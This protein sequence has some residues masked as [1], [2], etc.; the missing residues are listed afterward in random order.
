[1]ISFFRMI[2]FAAQHFFRNF[3]LSVVSII[4]LLLA[5]ISVN[6]FFGFNYVADR[7]I[8]TVQ[9]KIDLSLY[10]YQGIE[11]SEIAHVQ[12]YLNALS[13]VK[14]TEL[15]SA[16]QVLANFQ[17]KHKDNPDMMRSLTEVGGNPFGAMLILKVN[18][19]EDYNSVIASL[20]SDVFNKLI[21][22]RSYENHETAIRQLESFSRNV[23]IGL[24]AFTLL[25][26]FISMLIVYNT[27]KVMIYNHREE[28]QIMKLVGASNKFIRWPFMIEGMFSVLIA[29][30]L[31]IFIVYPF[32]LKF[33]QMYFSGLNVD[34]LSYF[35]TNFYLIFG[36]QLLGALLLNTFS[37]SIAVG[38][39]LN[40]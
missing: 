16:E 35:Q 7:A 39:Y 38:R 20:N 40:R 31:T 10:F 2:K 6:M 36:G 19:I 27:V 34:V 1:M 28:I 15:V 13:T 14:S 17:E 23:K 22:K 21:E 24:L 32:L 33:I 30:A 5:L 26:I 9:D 37:S 11:E 3:G 4:I 29:V 18:S 12:E 8:Q 25:F